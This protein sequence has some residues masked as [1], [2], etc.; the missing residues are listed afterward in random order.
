[1]VQNPSFS[2]KGEQSGI[3]THTIDINDITSQYQ[4]SKRIQ[5]SQI[6]LQFLLPKNWSIIETYQSKPGICLVQL[7]AT[8]PSSLP[9]IYQDP[10]KMSEKSDERPYFV[11][12][13][14]V[15]PESQ[16]H[17]FPDGFELITNNIDHPWH[18]VL[19]H[20]VTTNSLNNSQ[21]QHHSGRHRLLRNSEDI[22]TGKNK[23]SAKRRC[24]QSSDEDLNGRFMFTL[25]DLKQWDLHVPSS[26]LERVISWLAS[27]PLSRLKPFEIAQS[28]K[29]SD[30]EY[31]D[32]LIQNEAFREPQGLT[33]IQTSHLGK[34]P[35]QKYSQLDSTHWSTTVEVSEASETQ[36]NGGEG[37]EWEEREVSSAEWTP[38]KSA[39]TANISDEEGWRKA[40]SNE[41]PP[42]EDVYSSEED[43][44]QENS[45]DDGSSI[46]VF[47]QMPPGEAWPG[48]QFVAEP[49]WLQVLFQPQPINPNVA[50]FL[51]TDD[52]L[53]TPSPSVIVEDIGDVNVDDELANEVAGPLMPGFDHVNVSVLGHAFAFGDFALPVS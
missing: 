19:D 42:D 10:A 23:H 25:E 9:Q 2:T 36:N 11:R 12:S 3:F 35:T 16:S 41:E 45:S 29:D 5:L 26:P 34:K 37:E 39:L 24:V 27:I 52:H 46:H 33:K 32:E 7:R 8:E 49:H 4:N 17:E 30:R 1:V 47:T 22:E 31:Q 44:D 18:A 13:A 50:T 20:Q 51:R 21:G 43:S 40:D 38:D 14:A 6:Q 53:L 28:S 48:Q 15:S